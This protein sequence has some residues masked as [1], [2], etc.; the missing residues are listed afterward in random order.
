[1]KESIYNHIIDNGENFILYNAL[2]DEAAV[3]TKELYNIYES[4]H[5]NPDDLK[6]AYPDFYDYLVK[7]GIIVA[8]DI[9]EINEALRLNDSK[10]LA[11]KKAFHLTVNPTLKCNMNCW[12]CYED[13]RPTRMSEETLSR[14]CELIEDRMR[15]IRV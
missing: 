1:M 7:A 12:Y 15:P 10:G 11:Q 2:S 13:K 6:T 8:E 9:D 4:R 3:I 14:V 5:R